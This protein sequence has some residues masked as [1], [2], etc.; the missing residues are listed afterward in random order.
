MRVIFPRL[1]PVEDA[2][3]SESLDV[4]PRPL[5]DLSA[6]CEFGGSG[7]T[8]GHIDTGVLDIPG[9]DRRHFLSRDICLGFESSIRVTVHKAVLRR[10]ANVSGVPFF[11]FDVGERVCHL[12][13]PA[14][15]T[16]EDRHDH[17]SGEIPVRIERI[18]G[19]AV[20]IPVFIYEIHA[21]V[22]P[23]SGLDILKRQ[24]ASFC[25]IRRQ[26]KYSHHHDKSEYKRYYPLFHFYSPLCRFRRSILKQRH[27]LKRNR[28]TSP[29]CIT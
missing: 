27:M 21:L 26:N 24:F 29:S 18:S 6:V 3:A 7:K 23:F 19:D 2:G 11:R 4:S 16:A 10:P 20:H 28:V 12:G 25:G 5:S 8:T 17:P 15:H 13:G 9:D 14:V 22:V 1:I